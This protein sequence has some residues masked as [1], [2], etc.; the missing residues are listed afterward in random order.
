VRG[1][2]L[3]PQLL[4]VGL[5]HPRI[6]RDVVLGGRQHVGGAAVYLFVV[7]ERVLDL[8]HIHRLVVLVQQLYLVL[9]Q[10]QYDLVLNMLLP[11]G[12]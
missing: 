9:S 5:R 2:A 10:K 4:P 3:G 7:V 6:V 12:L 8:L 1:G 11:E